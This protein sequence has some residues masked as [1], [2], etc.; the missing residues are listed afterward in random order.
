MLIVI[1][2]DSFKSTATASE[3]ALGIAQGVTEVL[4]QATVKQ[5]P[6]A[7]GGEG[8]ADVIAHTLA[9]AKTGPG[10]ERIE[11][12]ST[13]ARGRLTTAHYFLHGDTAYID[14]AAASG[15]PAVEDNLDVRHADSYGTGVLIADAETRGAKHIVLGLGGSA[16]IDGG[17]GIIT[18]LGGAPLDERGLPLP[19]GGAPLVV[20]D[21]ID[22]AQ[23]NIK[24]AALKY[25]LLADTTC[26]PL[27]AASMYGRQKGATNEDIPLLTGALMKLCEVTGI[28]LEREGFGAAGAIPVGLTWLSSLLY[29]AES[30]IELLPGAHHVAE[31]LGL[32]ALLVDAQGAAQP[33]LVIT[34][35]GAY[36]E[37][38]STG[39]VVGTIA[40]L[41]QDTDASLAVVAGRLDS[42][43][44]PGAFAAQLSQQGSMH[45]QLKEAGRAI[46]KEFADSLS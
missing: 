30:N 6:M 44:P 39:K 34:G 1:A 31:L 42:P 26:S 4:P 32:R 7:D 11:L 23:L 37:Q 46:A 14:V 27:H 38:S 18:A 19:K 28:D 43:L 36:D 16:T 9:A 40:E 15:L 25:T 12:P 3:V 21:S 35:E 10:V 13:D 2:P 8:T 17:M 33:T 41:A 22:T 45:E 20:L 5:I 29:G 24:A